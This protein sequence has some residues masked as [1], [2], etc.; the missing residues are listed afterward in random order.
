MQKKN[1][2]SYDKT[3]SVTTSHTW[4]IPAKSNFLCHWGYRYVRKDVVIKGLKF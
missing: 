4:K 3:K 2:V 1:E